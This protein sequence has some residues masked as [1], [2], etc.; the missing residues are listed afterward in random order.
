M[1]SSLLC[2]FKKA[3]FSLRNVLDK[4]VIN[5][6]RWQPLSTCHLHWNGRYSMNCYKSKCDHCL[7]EQALVKLFW[8]VNFLMDH[9]FTFKECQ[10]NYGYS[11]LGIWQTFYFCLNE[12]VRD[13][14]FKESNSQYV[15]A[16][17]KIQVFKYKLEFQKTYSPLGDCVFPILTNF[18]DQS[19]GDINRC[20]SW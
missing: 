16:S 19:D 7:K 14:H 1:N 12:Q 6:I 15:V 8:V 11:H 3:T 5:F 17:D 4:A 10:T 18:C 20:E 2:C 13:C 9:V